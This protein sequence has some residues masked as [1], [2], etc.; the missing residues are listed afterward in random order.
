MLM[1]AACQHVEAL[2]IVAPA[3]LEVTMDPGSGGLVIED[4]RRGPGRR[5]GARPGGDRGRAGPPGSVPA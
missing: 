5:P 3:G 4:D 1:L 2:P